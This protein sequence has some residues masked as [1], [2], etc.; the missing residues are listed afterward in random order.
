M[1]HVLTITALS[2]VLLLSGCSSSNEKKA[3]ETPGTPPPVYKVQFDT[4]KGPFVVE[5]H[6]D[7]APYGAARLYELVGKGFYD[8]N[9]FFRVLRGFVAQF[10]IN[11]D[12]KV[13]REWMNSTLPDDPRARH[14]VRGTLTF[15]S[16]R[17]INSRSTQLFVNLHDNSETLDSQNFAPL[18]QVV[19]GMEVVD[20]L[21]AG[22]GEMPPSGSGPDPTQ[23][24]M[25]GNDYL[26]RNFP[27]LDYIKTATILKQ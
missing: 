9:R 21:W 8:G 6:S 25:Q 1:R 3:E 26:Q 10:G 24:Q 2:S 23:I 15:A 27:H 5:V 11:G 19:S 12:P 17:M 22:Y 18:G 7:W 13:N 4:S 20:D 16:T 14:N